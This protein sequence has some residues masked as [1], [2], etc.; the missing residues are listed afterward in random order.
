MHTLKAT[1]M[2][3]DFKNDLENEFNILMDFLG[4][5]YKSDLCKTFITDNIGSPDEK[6]YNIGT[7]EGMK[8]YYIKCGLESHADCTLIDR[9]VDFLQYTIRTPNYETLHYIASCLAHDLY[10]EFEQIDGTINN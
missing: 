4:Q 6:V 7:F 3:K 5:P 2:K 10:S 9:I 1:K 8:E